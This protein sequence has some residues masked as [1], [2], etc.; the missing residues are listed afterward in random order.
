[1]I[2]LGTKIIGSNSKGLCTIEGRSLSTNTHKG[3]T[4]VANDNIQP[5]KRQYINIDWL[6]GAADSYHISADIKDY[7]IIPVPIVTSD[8]PNRNMQAFPLGEL[9]LFDPVHGKFVYQTFTGKPTHCDHKN[10]DPEQ[11]KG[12]ILDSNFQYISK[13]NVGKVVTLAAFDRSKDWRLARSIQ[14]NERD[15]YSMG[16]FVNTFI[17]SVCG[18]VYGKDGKLNCIHQ[19]D[20][21]AP[22]VEVI[23]GKLNFM[24]C[25][26][27]TFFEESS[28]PSPADASAFVGMEDAL[29]VNM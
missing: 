24:V 21:Q 12:V 29:S 3:H 6:P 25:R 10:E 8:I 2:D 11:A 4:V 23:D 22:R 13:Y 18:S 1:M 9:T 26:G 5:S 27:V 17:C 16:A 15:S 20:P 19:L 14:N 28:V 7:I